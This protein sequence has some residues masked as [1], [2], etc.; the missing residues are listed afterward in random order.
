MFQQWLVADPSAAVPL[1]SIA[2]LGPEGTS[3]E[4]AAVHLWAARGRG[5]PSR[6]RLLDTYEE[7]AAEL[8]AGRVSH[9]LVANAYSGIN[10]F[11]MDREFSLAL[12]FVYDTPPYGLA[13]PCPGSVPHAVSIA[14]HPAAAPLVGE[15]LP[16]RHAVTTI[17]YTDSTSVAA[18][19]ARRAE[20]DLALTTQPA[21]LVHELEFI[22]RTRP[23]RMLWSAFTLHSRSEDP[24]S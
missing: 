9:L 4:S 12:A 23:I 17:L 15:L 10:T 3:S 13:T 6:V 18:A 7:A 20:T 8:K 2:T 14:T 19:T 24:C 21:A 11:Y 16:A 1:E 5:G 22:S